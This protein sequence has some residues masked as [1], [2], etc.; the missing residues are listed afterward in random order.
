[1]TLWAEL[2]P[3]VLYVTHDLREALAVADRVIFLS[4]GPARVVKELPVNLARPRDPFGEAVTEIHAQ[5]LREHPDLLSGLASH[6]RDHNAAN[7]ERR[8]A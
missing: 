2:R 8:T 7:P 3:T 1:M 4:S 6:E 5:L